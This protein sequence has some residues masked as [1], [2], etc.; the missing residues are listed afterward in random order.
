M[1]ASDIHFFFEQR[2]FRLLLAFLMCVLLSFI[3]RVDIFEKVWMYYVL[4]ALVLF[5]VFV[6]TYNDFGFLLL[7]IAM[8]SMTVVTTRKRAENK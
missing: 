7:L 1:F 6:N 2:G 3:D 8:L 4:C 5:M